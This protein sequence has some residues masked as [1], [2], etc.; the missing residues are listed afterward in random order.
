[1][2]Q[3]I[4]LNSQNNYECNVYGQSDDTWLDWFREVEVHTEILADNNHVT[5]FSDVVMGQAGL[6]GLVRRLHGLGIALVSISL[7]MALPR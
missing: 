7:E 1:M 2:S 4:S 5:T 3:S 6:V